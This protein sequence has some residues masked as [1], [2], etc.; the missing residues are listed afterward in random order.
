MKRIKLYAK[1]EDR[2]VD[3]WLIENVEQYEEYF[4]AEKRVCEVA[5]RETM[6]LEVNEKSSG[7]LDHW[8]SAY[9]TNIGA[10]MSGAAALSKIGEIEQNPI[11]KVEPLF[12][13][14]TLAI[15][16]ALEDGEKVILW[17]SGGWCTLVDSMF[18]I[19]GEQ[20]VKFTTMINPT[21]YIDI[22]K[23]SKAIILEN[24]AVIPS[25]VYKKTKRFNT[26]VS[27]I[28]FLK[29]IGSKAIAG[30]MNRFVE[31]G[32]DTIYAQTTGIDKEQLRSMAELVMLFDGKIKNVVVD[33]VGSDD[34]QEE[35]E[36]LAEKLR[37]HGIDVE[38]LTLNHSQ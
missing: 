14:K 37:E 6:L 27:S 28:R 13:G 4:K 8:C 36:I 19:R 32:G 21:D 25:I 16:R 11:F 12:L 3:A 31:G 38:V 1:L 22:R 30:A 23:N 2:V 5:I 20:E 35:V 26:N 15:K 17:N 9:P 33:F 7:K 24:A 34:D 10:Y 29:V 18:E